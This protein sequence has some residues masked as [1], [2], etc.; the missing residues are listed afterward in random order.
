VRTIIDAWNLAS[1][2]V[3]AVVQPGHQ[4]IMSSAYWPNCVGDKLLL[5]TPNDSDDPSEIMFRRVRVYPTF[6]VIE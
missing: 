1:R 2:D 5:Y 6:Q 4:V 3:H